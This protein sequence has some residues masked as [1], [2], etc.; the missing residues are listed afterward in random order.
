MSSQLDVYIPVILLMA[1]AVIAFVGAVFLVA[2]LLRPSAPNPMK[3][4][5][6]ECGEEPIGQAWVHFNVRFYVISLIFI[7][8]DVEGALMFPVASVFRKFNRI[9]EGGVILGSL[10]IFIAVLVV[11]IVYCWRKGDFDWVK[12]FR[13]PH[14]E[15]GK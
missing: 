2:R 14:K 6:Y 5:P 15:S 13:M 11:G 8:F 4:T 7:I 12:S 3:E 9:G 1:F 10:L